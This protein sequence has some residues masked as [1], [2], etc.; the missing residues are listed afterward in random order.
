[1]TPSAQYCVLFDPT[2]VLTPENRRN[3]G[4]LGY[5]ACELA[6]SLLSHL[7]ERVSTEGRDQVP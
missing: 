6:Q 7:D 4:E 3:T 2:F 5:L 1:M